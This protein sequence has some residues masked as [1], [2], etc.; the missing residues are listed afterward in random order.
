MAAKSEDIQKKIEK[1]LGSAGRLKIL[2]TLA[3]EEFSGQTKY[4]LEKF[5]N[6]KPIDIRKHLK[7]LIETEWVREYNYNPP[8]Y[9]LNLDN[10]KTKAL[11]E[12]F[13]K[14]GYL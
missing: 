7:V 6:L 9:T 12:F 13:K 8:T 10:S 2:R 1:S 14:I 5:T 3:Y 11:V 4:S